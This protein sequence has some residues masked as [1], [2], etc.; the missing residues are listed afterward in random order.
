M[1]RYF[2]FVVA[3]AGLMAAPAQADFKRITS[4]AD[5]RKAAVGKTLWLD[6]NYFTV[7]RRGTLDGNF[8]GTKIKGAWEW[9]DGFWCRTLT[10]P[11]Q[12]SDCQLWEVDGKSF[13]ATRNKGKG[14][15]FIYKRR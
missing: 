7:R 4:E 1:N 2:A 3:F 5:F 12:N 15:S 9:R 8:G 10:E 11:R 14:K 6:K 13:R